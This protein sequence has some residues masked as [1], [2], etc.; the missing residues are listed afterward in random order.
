MKKYL[1][2]LPFVFLA[3]VVILAVGINFYGGGDQGQ[4]S[5]QNSDD[6]STLSDEE[7]MRRN[8]NDDDPE[9]EDFDPI[10]LEEDE[11]IDEQIRRNN[12]EADKYTPKERERIG[13]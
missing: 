5:D 1:S 2:K 7:Q 10:D 4:R 3:L 11:R 13:G 6:P 12:E 8:Y 9:P